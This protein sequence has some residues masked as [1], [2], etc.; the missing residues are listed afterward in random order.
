MK[1]IFCRFL[2][3]LLLVSLT[4]PAPSVSAVSDAAKEGILPNTEK[5][6][7]LYSQLKKVSDQY[8]SGSYFTDDGKACTHHYRCR[9]MKDCNCKT[10]SVSEGGTDGNFQCFGF[11]RYVFYQLFGTPF[12]HYN[13]RRNW[14]VTGEE[15][16]N[17]TQVF[18][19][20]PSTKITEKELKEFFASCSIG[21]VIQTGIP[22]T[23]L[24]LN[25]DDEGVLVYDCN[26]DLRTCQVL[27]HRLSWEQLARYVTQKGMSVYHA[28][29]YPTLSGEAS[30]ICTA[31]P[32]KALTA[33]GENREGL[34]FRYIKGDVYHVLTCGED[35]AFSCFDGMETQRITDP[36]SRGL[37][38]SV[39]PGERFDSG[40]VIF[41][42]LGAQCQINAE[43]WPVSEGILEFVPP[44]KTQYQVGEPLSVPDVYVYLAHPEKGKVYCSSQ[45][46]VFTGFD[47]TKEGVCTVTVDALGYQTQFQVTVLRAPQT[48]SS[49]AASEKGNESFVGALFLTILL[50]A[51][52]LVLFVLRNPD[53][54]RRKGR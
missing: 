49:S 6:E 50:C 28:T 34:T 7:Y 1:K 39:L 42:Y 33:T 24:Y 2:I 18:T 23:M 15:M 3:L 36:A 11:V 19:A 52:A 21:D 43:V 29:A 27:S 48:V 13:S 16:T 37:S 20:A 26:F 46:L 54:L 31:L 38:L 32:K 40:K 47:S 12:P 44:A 17:V 51:A 4:H 53:F 22:H 8:P 10:I 45:D 30:L 25:S 41:S 35:G 14:E 5:I 9:E